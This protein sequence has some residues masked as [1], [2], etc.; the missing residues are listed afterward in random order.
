MIKVERAY[1]E[2]V[3][4]LGEESAVALPHVQVP[5]ALVPLSRLRV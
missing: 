2:G 3:L 1:S 5:L 4:V